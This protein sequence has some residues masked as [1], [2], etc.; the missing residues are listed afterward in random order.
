VDD[1]EDWILMWDK[2][3]GVLI[4]QLVPRG[5]ICISESCFCSL[6]HFNFSVVR[7]FYACVCSGHVET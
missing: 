3:V 4:G 5:P 2:V 7:S 6:G 1:L